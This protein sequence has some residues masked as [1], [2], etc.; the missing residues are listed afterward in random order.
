MLALP[1]YKIYC[2]DLKMFGRKKSLITEKNSLCCKQNL[3]SMWKCIFNNVWKYMF[4]NVVTVPQDSVFAD[5]IKLYL[6]SFS[7]MLFEIRTVCSKSP[8]TMWY[9]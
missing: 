6:F 1:D 3:K 7:F 2:S 8:A 5:S 9:L 4:N